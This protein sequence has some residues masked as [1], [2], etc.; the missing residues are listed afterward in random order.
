M[1]LT[2]AQRNATYLASPKGQYSK[3]KQ[4]AA[5]RGVEFLLSFDQWLGLWKKS[6][7]WNKRGNRKGCFCMARH[8]DEGPYALGNVRI[9]TWSGNTA[10]RNRTVIVK[11]HRARSTEVDFHPEGITGTVEDAS[12]A[13]F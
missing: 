11:R 12:E 2:Q 7:K 13:P 8:G 1:A 3:H 10:E 9:E 6:G 4:N 5:R